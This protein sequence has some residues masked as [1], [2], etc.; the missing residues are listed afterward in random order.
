MAVLT[1]EIPDEEMSWL[2]SL[3]KIQK[4]TKAEIVRSALRRVFDENF[5]DRRPILVCEEE[6][7]A[8][9]AMIDRPLTQEQIEGRRR[10]EAHRMWKLPE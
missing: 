6:F 2:E 4:K 5:I 8:I 1:V 9:V 10:P 7:D 3:A